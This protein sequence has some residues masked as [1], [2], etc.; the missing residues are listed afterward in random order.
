MISFQD[1]YK[2]QVQYPGSNSYK[3]AGEP[4]NAEE[5]GDVP[6]EELVKVAG[7]RASV[8]EAIE[9]LK[10]CCLGFWPRAAALTTLQSQVTDATPP[11]SITDTITVPLKYHEAVTSQGTIFRTLRRFGVEAE[12]S[13]QPTRSSLPSRPSSSTALAARV[14][15]A[16]DTV[17][18]AY[19]ETVE[20]YTDA[21]EGESTWNLKAR[22]QPSIDKAKDAITEAIEKAKTAT[23]VGFLTLPDR[24]SFARIVGA[25]GS[26][27]ARLHEMTN[28][29]IHVG[30]ENS[31][32][33]ITGS[34]LPSRSWRT[35][36][37]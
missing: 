24:S 28:A 7:P 6:P 20:N 9:Q 25:K 10:V 21:E 13:A 19:W 8:V 18:E 14:D 16:E 17:T 37:L 22:D 12:L 31:T 27:I 11:E 3:Y 23:H 30:R 29:N 1:K 32:I 36:N 2:V 33:I 5:L 26:N 4:E 35:Q 34:F 15:D